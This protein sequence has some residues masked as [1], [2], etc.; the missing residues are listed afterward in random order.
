MADFE[1]N[2]RLSLLKLLFT[3]VCYFCFHLI[4]VIIM[5]ILSNIVMDDLDYVV[6][7]RD[8]IHHER[9]NPFEY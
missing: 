3:V 4:V 9:I 2:V 5:N 1:V 6:L 7:C 8:R